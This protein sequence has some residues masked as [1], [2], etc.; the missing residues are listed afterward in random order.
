MQEVA[1]KKDASQSL[2]I[3]EILT[4][5]LITV[6]TSLGQVMESDLS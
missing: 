6:K 3:N 2:I 5:L 4:V 1:L